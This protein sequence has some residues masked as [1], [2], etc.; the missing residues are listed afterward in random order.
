MSYTA[1]SASALIVVACSA[2][3]IA[4][5]R[6]LDGLNIRCVATTE[7]ESSA[8]AKLV[9]GDV[10]GIFYLV[11]SSGIRKFAIYDDKVVAEP[12]KNPS[13]PRSLYRPIFIHS[14]DGQPVVARLNNGGTLSL[15][16]VVNSRSV[17]DHEFTTGVVYGVAATKDGKHL[18]VTSPQHVYVV[19]KSGDKLVSTRQLR[20]SIPRAFGVAVDDSSSRLA[21]A[22]YDGTV[23][24]WNLDDVIHGEDLQPSVQRNIRLPVLSLRFADRGS[25]L[26]A[27]CDC[28]PEG[29][30]SM[31]AVDAGSG[32]DAIVDA[33]CLDDIAIGADSRCAFYIKRNYRSSAE[34]FMVVDTK[35]GFTRHLAQARVQ[36]SDQI[37]TDAKA[38]HVA[39]LAKTGSLAFYRVIEE[40]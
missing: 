38:E 16:Q 4:N 19:R 30:I 7:A 29:V 25:S 5:D 22:G 10:S 6:Y 23:V 15:H 37:A 34:R 17:V 40:P 27:V 24:I 21:I 36:N 31:I 13:G 32:S 35:R 9:A 11:G 18:F 3:A 39:V 14:D 33:T 1:P 8:G 2:V 26:L 12:I 20:H 28:S